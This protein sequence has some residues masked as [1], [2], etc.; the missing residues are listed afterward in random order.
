MNT[1]KLVKELRTSRDAFVAEREELSE[2]IAVIDE[3]LRKLGAKRGP[4]RPKGSGKKAEVA[5]APAAPRAAV[6]KKAKRNW[7]PEAKAAAS[8]RMKAYWA[9]KR[10]KS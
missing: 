1:D 5:A 4:G 2:K 9:D 6:R 7:S 10:K 8:A 3:T